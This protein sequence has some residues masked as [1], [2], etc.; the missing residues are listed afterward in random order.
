MALKT[1]VLSPGDC[2]VL[3]ADVTVV[4]VTTS[5]TITVTSSCGEL[6]TPTAFKCWR[7][8]WGEDDWTGEGDAYFTSVKIGGTTYTVNGA[9][10][11][12]ANSWDNGSAFLAQAIPVSTPAGLVTDIYSSGGTAVHPK[13]LVFSIPESLGQP[14]IFWSNPGFENAAYYGEEDECAC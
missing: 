13:C 1:I 6:P 7:F 8:K 9:P 10:V 12:E 2:S 5:G 3:P 14:I 11:S 4:A